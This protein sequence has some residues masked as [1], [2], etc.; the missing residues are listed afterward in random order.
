[1]N[2]NKWYK[3]SKLYIMDMDTSLTSFK[4][5][6][7]N[8]EK[9]FENSIESLHLVCNLNSNDFDSIVKEHLI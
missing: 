3:S 9:K 4:S 1:M 6:F 7:T 2:Y 5:S 8:S